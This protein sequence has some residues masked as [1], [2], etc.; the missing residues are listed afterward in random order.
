MIE[1]T[2]EDSFTVDSPIKAIRI[3]DIVEHTRRPGRYLLTLSD[4]RTF[5]LSASLLADLGATRRG[6]ELDVATVRKIESEAE[7]LRVMDRA[8]ASL[9]RGRRTRR[10]LAQR[11]RRVKPGVVP[12]DAAVV[13]MA[14]NR[15]EESG[16]ISDEAVAR[17]EASS[18]L[19]RG[20]A[21]GRVEMIL[22]RKGIERRAASDAVSE[23]V[24]EDA[25][26]VDAQCIAVAAKRMRS[27]AKLETKV[28]K[29]RLMAFLMRRGYGSSSIRIAIREHFEPR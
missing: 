8:I 21:P 7:V 29:R 27:L 6:L 15:L 5:T 9:S 3:A 28:A 18:R 14:L 24:I 13:A 19:R 1:L 2:G 22:Q 10:E 25:I 17:A 26:D 11:L 16:L 12:P 23:V 4:E 20:D